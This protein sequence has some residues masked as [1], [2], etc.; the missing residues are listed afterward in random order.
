MRHTV[1]HMPNNLFLN[2]RELVDGIELNELC[3]LT[4]T[5]K[6]I[7]LEKERWFNQPIRC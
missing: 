2:I 4:T 3:K 5:A 7:V 1:H 6:L